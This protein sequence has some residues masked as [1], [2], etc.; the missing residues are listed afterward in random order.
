[1]EDYIVR[2]VTGDGYV[3]AAAVYGT[4]LCERTRVIHKT[5]PLATAA[6]GRALCAAS[7]MGDELK[8]DRASVTLQFRGDGPLGAITAVSDSDGCVRGYLQNPAAVLPLRADGKLDVGRGVGEGVLGVIK[9]IGTGD[10]FSGKVELRSGEIAE[11]IAAYYTLSEQIPTACALG[12]LVDTDQGVRAAGGYLIQLMPGAPAGLA[13]LLEYRVRDVG[14]VTAA[15]ERGLTPETI[16]DELL[17]SMDFTIL[18]KHAISYR[19]R[20]SQERVERALISMGKAE[21]QKLIDDPEETSVTCQFCDAVYR[22]DK[23]YLTR[24]LARAGKKA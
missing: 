21:L 10:P 22:F 19:C 5:L 13:D 12:V 7:M 15:M 17:H 20:C 23:Q 6:L 24:L 8:D 11:D 9:D 4:G 1:M 14:S 18:E 2:G 3:K 16:L